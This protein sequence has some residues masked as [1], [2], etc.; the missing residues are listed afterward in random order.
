VSAP[1]TMTEAEA[2]DIT[3]RIRASLDVAWDLLVRAYLQGAWRALG[4]ASWDAYTDAE[5]GETRLRIPREQRRE[6][7]ASM[8]DAGMSTRAIGSALG[9]TQQTV[10]NNRAAS[11]VK[12][13]TPDA[14]PIPAGQTVLTDEGAVADIEPEPRRVVGTDGKTYTSRPQPSLAVAGFVADSQAV[15]DSGYVRAFVASL[16]RVNDFL[17]FDPERLAALLDHDE[18]AAVERFAAS[19]SRFVDAL[20][21]NRSGLRVIQGEVQP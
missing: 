1:A 16:A 5:L 3:G 12:F 14:E 4:Y 13:L 6:L 10:A 9:V 21:R 19:A 17:A 2:R 18:T 7:V 11:G 15:A 8:S 20:R